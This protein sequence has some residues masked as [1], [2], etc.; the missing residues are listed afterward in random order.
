MPTNGGGGV[1][2]LPEDS[3]LAEVHIAF[4][5]TQVKLLCIAG[6]GK[7]GGFEGNTFTPVLPMDC[8]GQK[9]GKNQNWKL[10]D[11]C[12]QF[13]FTESCDLW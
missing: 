13:D 3:L 2:T 7:L 6:A 9:Q 5:P 1:S 10:L 4:L 11:V 8:T 12:S